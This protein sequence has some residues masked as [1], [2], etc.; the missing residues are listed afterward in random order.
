MTRTFL[1]W[2]AGGMGA[3]GAVLLLA[4]MLMLGKDVRGHVGDTY[5]QYSAD[6][7]NGRYEC[8]GSP[9]QVADEI[10]RYDAPEARA[11]DRGTEYLRYND[12]IVTV[13][14][15]G[16]YPCSIRVEDTNAR[17]SGGGFIFLGPGFTPGSPAG[18]SGGSPGG[19]GGSK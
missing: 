17:Y 10:A 16:Q 13:G 2:L 1:F 4:G 18:G 19:P 7:G 3:L 14:P 12:D 8:S 11:S 5:R 9:K 15:D 6:G